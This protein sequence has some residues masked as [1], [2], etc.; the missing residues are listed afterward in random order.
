MHLDMGGMSPEIAG[1]LKI[2]YPELG[3]TVNVPKN[4]T[5]ARIL[6]AMGAT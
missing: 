2:D 4:A 1:K 6:L 5:A 3:Y